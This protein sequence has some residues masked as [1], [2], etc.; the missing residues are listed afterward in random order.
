M[1][2]HHSLTHWNIV[3]PDH[4]FTQAMIRARRA[5]SE[6]SLRGPDPEPEEPPRGEI[7]P[8][9]PTDSPAPAEGDDR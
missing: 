1:S 2:K 5:G 6:P 7:S 9:I 8:T 4:P 3:G